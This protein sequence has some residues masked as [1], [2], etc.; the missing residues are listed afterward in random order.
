MGKQFCRSLYTQSLPRGMTH[1]EKTEV[2]NLAR[3]LG[4]AQSED[5]A[6]GC[7]VRFQLH[8]TGLSIW[9]LDK[10]GSSQCQNASQLMVWSQPG[11]HAY[12]RLSEKLLSLLSQIRG[13]LPVKSSTTSMG[14]PTGAS[15]V[16]T[17]G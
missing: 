7:Q 6:R 10:A 3:G 9:C 4:V 12:R 5:E 14:S 8:Q 1:T 13:L 15:C 11:K 2:G 17:R 16:L